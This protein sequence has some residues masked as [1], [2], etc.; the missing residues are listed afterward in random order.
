MGPQ[1]T[2]N[3]ILTVPTGA[4]Q[5]VRDQLKRPLHD[6]RISVIDRCNF[7]CPYCMP[8]DAVAHSYPFLKEKDWLSFEEIVRLA[9]L[10]VALGVAKIRLTG[11]EPLL[12]PGLLDLIR[13]VRGIAGIED[14]ALTTNASLLAGQAQALRAAGLDRIN[15][16]LDTLNE[17]RFRH[18]S[19]GRGQLEDVLK[20]ITAAEIA[21]FK[22]VKVNVVVQRGVNEDEVLNLVQF[23]RGRKAILRFIEFMDVGNC[24]HWDLRQVVPAREILK[25]IRAVFPVT[26]AAPQYYGEVAERYTFDNGPSE[27]GFISSVTQP[28]CGTCTRARLSAD[29]KLYTCLFA[30]EGFDLKALLRQEAADEK[31]M[32]ILTKIWHNRT[33]RYS[34]QRS[35]QHVT[36]LSTHKVE[37]FQI[38]G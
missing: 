18:L 33:D 4:G 8:A 25:T 28:F 32:A 7:R 34:E 31:I 3:A 6:L 9:R 38:G 5:A 24:N 17:E 1:A 15:I 2:T 29:G 36:P 14:F 35:H 22:E 27:V 21:G 20:G 13:Q 12:R 19:G 26:P 30:G 11:G 37:M 10:F 16:S 23:F